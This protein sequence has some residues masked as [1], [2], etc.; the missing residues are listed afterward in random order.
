MDYTTI[1]AAIVSGVLGIG[2]VATFMTKYMPIVTKWAMIAKDA[3][4]TLSDVADALKDGALSA[5][6][7]TKLKADVAKFMADLKA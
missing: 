2:A 5:D 3:V 7:I 4:E 1:A 6:E